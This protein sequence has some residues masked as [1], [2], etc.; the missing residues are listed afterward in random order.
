[1]PLAER[2]KGAANRGLDFIWAAGRSRSRLSRAN[3]SPLGST[4]M[5]VALGVVDLKG[6]ALLVSAVQPPVWAVSSDPIGEC[7]SIDKRPTVIT[8]SNRRPIW[9]IESNV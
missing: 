8:I 6:D 2:G 5:R 4:T 1:M 3:P 7:S 9:W